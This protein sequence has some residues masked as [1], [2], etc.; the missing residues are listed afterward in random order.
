MSLRRSTRVK[1]FGAVSP[2]AVTQPKAATKK[3]GRE[4][5]T[6]KTST[7]RTSDDSMKTETTTTSPLRLPTTPAKKRKPNNESPTKLPPVTPTPS[8]IGLMLSSTPVTR[9]TGDIDDAI[10]SARPAEPQHTNAPLQISDSQTLVPS[11]TTLA[12]SSGT[13]SR[14]PAITTT[15]NILHTAEQHL[16]SI[17]P[18]LSTVIKAHHCS[19]FSPSGLAEEIDPF[20]SLASGIMAQQVSGAAA[21]SIKNKFISL[22]AS[23]PHFPSAAVVAATDIATL[24]SAGLSQ[25]KA[26]YIQGLAQKFA[27]GELSAEMLAQASGEEVMERLVAVRG[28]GRWSVE[29]F[30]C[31]GLKR[32]DVF[33]T[34]D[35]GVQRGMAAYLGKDVGK[36]RNKGGKWK[37]L[38]EKEMLDTAA[39]FSPY[40]SL[41][42]WYMWRIEG[43]LGTGPGTNVNAIQDGD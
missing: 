20:R 15:T 33:S 6:D 25:R 26:E 5:K 23:A 7:A 30:C 17:D 35:L 1:A 11:S 31:F 38:S 19:V 9:S 27:D 18:S 14:L 28:L 29:M 41:F 36:L 2:V 40:R 4:S 10:P 22:F 13:T 37:Y 8:A 16:L 39:K 42:M 3:R 43:V 24:R 12:S 34:G 32:M 21:S